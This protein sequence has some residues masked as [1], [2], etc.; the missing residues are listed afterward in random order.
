MSP[1]P[2]KGWSYTLPAAMALMAPFNVLAS[3]AMDIYLPIVPTMPDILGTTPG[4]VQ[5]T[6]T[7]YMIVLGVGQVVFGP[8]SDRIGRRP[9][10]FGGAL[11]FALASLLLACVT[12]AGMFVALRI[13]QAMGAS[14][15]LVALFATVRDVYAD[16]PESVTVYG[17]LNAM[18]AFVPAIGPILG[19]VVVE[20]AGWPGVFVALGVP[21]ILAI[22]HAWPRWHETRPMI[23]TANAG[24]ALPVLR[25]PA[26]WAYTLAFSAAMG[27][28]FVFFSTAPRVLI[29]RA[30]YS[31]FGFSIAF[32]TA[33][34]VMI[35]TARFAR[36]IA[37]RWGVRGGV[38]VGMA[39]L[40]AGA[41]A[42]AMGEIVLDPSFASF[43]LRCGSSQRASSSPRRSRPMAP[44]QASATEP[45]PPSRSISASRA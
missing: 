28:F 33:A 43:V 23:R 29:D 41:L 7:A 16:R 34:L 11:T 18:L 44:L 37:G 26:F 25:S 12:S 15:A 35:A 27:S 20:I 32:A 30:G 3:L 19:A 9:V 22:L 17:A 8:L 31:E 2:V 24:S 42:L 1:D 39:L 21:A 13:V 36:L 5:L 40:L 6:L 45:A 38:V 14:A 4:V 10:L